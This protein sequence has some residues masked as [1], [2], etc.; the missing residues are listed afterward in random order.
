MSPRLVG[1][2]VWKPWWMTPK[3]NPRFCSL[4]S[5]CILTYCLFSLT[6]SLC[7]SLSL[8]LSQKQWF[9][10]YLT[11]PFNTVPPVVILSHK[12]TSFATSSLSLCYH[13]ESQCWYLICR[14]AIGNPYQRVL[15]S[16]RGSEN[17]CSKDKKK[18]KHCPLLCTLPESWRT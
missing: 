16:P 6:V 12:M 4:T 11:Q 8:F 7:L 18:G 2:P 14:V 13:Y 9:L 1:D 17:H 3:T 10:T 5:T 15:G